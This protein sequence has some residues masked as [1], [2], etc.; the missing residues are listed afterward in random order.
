MKISLKFLKLEESREKHSMNDWL[1]IKIRERRKSVRKRNLQNK[2][3]EEKRR[4]VKIT[5]DETSHQLPELPDCG[6]NSIMRDSCTI[7]GN[8]NRMY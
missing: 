5:I 6:I 7:L 3:K 1:E 8:S 4:I 2:R